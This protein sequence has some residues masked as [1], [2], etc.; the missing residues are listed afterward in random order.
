[1]CKRDVS[2]PLYSIHKLQPVTLNQPKRKITCAFKEAESI[3]L[4]LPTNLDERKRSQ[5]VFV[6]Y[7][8]LILGI[9]YSSNRMKSYSVHVRVVL[10]YIFSLVVEKS[11]NSHKEENLIFSL[12]KTENIKYNIR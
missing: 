12:W 6:F 10:P 7:V 5:V 9:I 2:I 8:I 1:M 3:S 4:E 11:L